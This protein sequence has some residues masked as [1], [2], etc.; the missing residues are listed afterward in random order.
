MEHLYNINIERAVLSSVFFKPE[1]LDDLVARIDSAVFYLPFHKALYEVMVELSSENLPID[2]TFVKDRLV[3][4]KVYDEVMMLDVLSVNAIS[5]L[6]AYIDDLSERSRKRALVA[7]SSDIRKVVSED[8]EESSE[9][10]GTIDSKLDGILNIGSKL[11]LKTSAHF[12]E[13][14]QVDMKK[15]VE[16]GDII[17]Y[18][19]GIHTL[20]AKIGAF[21]EGDLVVIA[22]RPSMGKTSLATTMTDYALDKGDGVLID[23]LEMSGKKIMARLVATRSGESLSDMKRGRVKDVGRFNNA[24]KFYR[25][26]TLLHIHEESYIPIHELKAKAVQKFRK[27]PNIKYWFI[28]HLRYIKKPG[29]NIPNEINEITKRIE[30]GWQAVW[31]SGV[32][33]LT[34]EQG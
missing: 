19:S 20:D 26:S 13:E 9:I 33:A 25:D 3:K 21:Q 1:R 18:K 7:L 29:L 24:V 28:D 14:M 8:D 23:S 15:A 2:D 22:A 30:K 34:A 4:R 6:D 32:S 10:V 16:S 17:G 31:C 12:V 11:S 5:S 27:H